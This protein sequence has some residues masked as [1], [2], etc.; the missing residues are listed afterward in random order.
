MQQIPLD[1]HDVRILDILQRDSQIPRL[2]LAEQVNLSSSQ[3]F[4]RIR[5]L[6]E[7][8]LIRRYSIEL[9]KQ[10]AGFDVAAMVMIQYRKSEANARQQLRDLIS[11]TDEILECYSITGEY[12]FLLKVYCTGM[13]AFNRLINHT[14]QVS[15]ISG[16]HSYM[17]LECIKDQASLPIQAR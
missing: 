13:A 5:R 1:A 11:R 9:D 7:S 8:G 10:K 2:Q 4:R 15:F 3:C 6:E 14:F 17:L 16:I 12:D